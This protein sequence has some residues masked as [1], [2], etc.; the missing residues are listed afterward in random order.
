MDR[1]RLQAFLNAVEPDRGAT[2][3]ECLPIP[4]GYS[5]D[6]ARATVQWADGTTESFFLRGDL[7]FQHNGICHAYFFFVFFF[8]FF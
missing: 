5:R 3:L 2:V 4:G 8:A 7:I 6:T 1:D